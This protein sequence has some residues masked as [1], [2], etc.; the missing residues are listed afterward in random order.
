MVS[1]KDFHNAARNNNLDVVKQATA[2]GSGLGVDSED[3]CGNSPLHLAAL[4]GHQAVAEHLIRHRADVN[5]RNR[6]GRW[7]PLHMAAKNGHQAMVECLMQHGADAKYLNSDLNAPID[8]AKTQA[9][10]DLLERH[11]EYEIRRL[12][13]SASND[14]YHSPN[15]HYTGGGPANH[16][17]RGSGSSSSD[18]ARYAE[19]DRRDH[20]ADQDRY[21]GRIWDWG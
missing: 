5:K 18:G 19:W 15:P 4:N 8:V 1:C 2:V 10:K 11:S 20:Y 17:S 3:D 12:C 13:P 9:I 21:G 6:N 7:T 16:D 14:D